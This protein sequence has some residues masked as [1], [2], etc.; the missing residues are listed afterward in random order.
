MRSALTGGLRILGVIG[1]LGLMVCA[2]IGGVYVL[3]AYAGA[4]A[5]VFMAGWQLFAP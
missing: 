2:A 1:Q 4:V 3:G 5:R